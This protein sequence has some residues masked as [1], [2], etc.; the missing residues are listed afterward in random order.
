MINVED[1]YT[2]VDQ[3]PIVEKQRLIEHVQKSIRHESVFIASEEER[4]RELQALYG[5]LADDPIERPE[6]P[7]LEERDPIE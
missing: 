1:L 4:H 6:Q 5:I 3:L 7:P 2:L